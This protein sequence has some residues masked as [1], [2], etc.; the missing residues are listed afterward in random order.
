MNDSTNQDDL[1]LKQM[2]EEATAA[3][4]ADLQPTDTETA[5]LREAWLAFGQL[6]R[7]ADDSLPAMPRIATHKPRA[8]PADSP[9]DNLPSPRPTVR[10]GERGAVGGLAWLRPP[11]R[12]CSSRSLSPGGFVATASRTIT[13]RRL[14]KGLHPSSQRPEPPP[15]R[16]WRSKPRPKPRSRRR[17]KWPTSSRRPAQRLHRRGMIRWKH[18]WSWC[19]SRSAK[20]STIGSTAWMTWISCSTA[21]TRSPILYRTINCE[22]HSYPVLF[23]KELN[24]CLG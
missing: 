10:V 2:L 14:R 4:P 18:R 6:I 12:R 23:A 19:R 1:P 16:Q 5:S 17:R 15:H 8:A 24:E 3:D 11:L 7:A 21:S 22:T 13:Y 9:H 20:S